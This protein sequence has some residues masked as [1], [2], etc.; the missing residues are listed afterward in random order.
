VGHLNGS[1]Q[2]QLEVYFAELKRLHLL[3]SIDSKKTPSLLGP[4]EGSPK[5]RSH[6]KIS[7]ELAI[8]ECCNDRLS[9]HD[10]SE[11]APHVHRFLRNLSSTEPAKLRIVQVVKRESS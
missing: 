2:D 9:R 4:I 7:S 3:P 1:R 11:L 8:R 5:D 10:L 6:L